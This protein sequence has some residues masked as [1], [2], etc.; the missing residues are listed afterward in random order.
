MKRMYQKR[1]F[2]NAIVKKNWTFLFILHEWREGVG[3]RGGEVGHTEGGGR[4]GGVHRHIWRGK[5]AERR[6]GVQLL[7][8]EHVF[9]FLD[10]TALFRTPILEPDF[11]LKLIIGK[12][13]ISS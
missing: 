6:V 5:G 8:N 10:G 4:K 9:L 12:L 2:Y 7:F 1:I 3:E 11:H 13:D